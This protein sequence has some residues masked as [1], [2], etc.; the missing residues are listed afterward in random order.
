MNTSLLLTALLI[1]VFGIVHSEAWWCNGHMLVAT[2]G[3]RDLPSSTLDWIT[4]L[5]KYHGQ[6]YVNSSTFQ[7]SACWPDDLKAY[8]VMANEEWHFA[9]FPYVP[10]IT[11]PPIP[12]NRNDSTV[13]W[14]IQQSI[15]VL[16]SQTT[17]TQ[18]RARYLSFL[19][20]FIGDI[21]QPLHVVTEYSQQFPPPVGDRGGNLF[22]IKGQNET[23]LHMFWDA[24][25][26]LWEEDQTRPLN[27]DGET[28]LNDWANQITNKYPR[29]YFADELGQSNVFDWA[30][31][32]FSWAVNDAYDTVNHGYL[33]QEYIANAQDI[34]MRAVALAGYRLADTLNNIKA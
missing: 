16:N 12:T 19:I 3:M 13:L 9:S 5:V 11:T 14:A 22:K 18:D 33:S 28:F 1:G 25:A 34:C 26:G 4:P 23:S 27:A 24:G 8:G 31:L 30:V 20:H 15:A 21:H 32:G 6:T 17:L 7:T 29:S 2:I 10:D